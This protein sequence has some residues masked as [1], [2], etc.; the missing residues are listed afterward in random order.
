MSVNNRSKGQTKYYHLIMIL[1]GGG[2]IFF[3]SIINL[4]FLLIYKVLRHKYFLSQMYTLWN[5][6][7]SL[8]LADFI[9]K[10]F[11]LVREI[12]TGYK[13]CTNNTMIS[14]QLYYDIYTQCIF[15]LSFVF[16]ICGVQFSITHQTW[17]W[18]MY[19]SKRHHA[20]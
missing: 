2:C 12:E 13:G 7:T 15:S 1:F 10:C 20:V 17:S 5:S 3:F 8:L 11:Y 18:C 14:Y 19:T 16:G 4:P 9:L 6:H